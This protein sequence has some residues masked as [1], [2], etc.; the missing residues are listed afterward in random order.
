MTALTGSTSAR[1]ADGTGPAMPALN[2]TYDGAG[3]PTLTV[4]ENSDGTTCTKF[5][6]Q[7]QAG[8]TGI[9]HALLAANAA[10]GK[11]PRAAV[12]A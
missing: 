7:A 11:H 3:T 8:L 9:P 5:T 6:G 2:F 10:T 12:P 1:A 4:T